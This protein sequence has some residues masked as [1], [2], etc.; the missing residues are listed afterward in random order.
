MLEA[1]AVRLREGRLHRRHRRRTPGKF[2]Q[3]Q[4]G[5]LLLDEISEMPLALQ[6]KLLRVLQERE[7]ERLGARKHDRARRARDRDHQP[8]PRGRRCSAGR[9]REDLYYRLS[10]FPLHIPPLRDRTGDILPLS[11]TRCAGTALAPGRCLPSRTPRG[12]RWARIAGPATCASWTTS[13]SGPSCSAGQRDRARAPALRDRRQRNAGHCTCGR[14]RV[15]PRRRAA[16]AGVTPDPAGTGEG[17]R[18]PQERRGTPRNQPAHVAS[19]AL[20]RCA[21]PASPSPKTEPRRVR[22]SSDSNE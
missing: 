18:Q 17:S 2:E 16:L 19:Q 5:T 8:G 11:S 15:A 22:R 12:L 4:G 3:A 21:P 9:F 1:H 13:R 10:V 6:A 20:P 14:R 7:V